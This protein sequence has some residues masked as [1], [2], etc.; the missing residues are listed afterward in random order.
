MTQVVLFAGGLAF[1]L[2][3]AGMV[4]VSALRVERASWSST[5]RLPA[6]RAATPLELLITRLGAV[7][8]ITGGCALVYVAAQT[9]TG[10]VTRTDAGSSQGIQR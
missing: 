5:S 9:F 4:A 7:L 8:A 3:I 6:K 1:I 2:G 10:S